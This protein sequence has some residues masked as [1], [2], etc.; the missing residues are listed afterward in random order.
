MQP[1]EDV[2]VADGCD[3]RRVKAA[4]V[5]KH[6]KDF[7]RDGGAR[8]QEAGLDGERAVD[9]VPEMLPQQRHG[10]VA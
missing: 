8:F 4:Q 10:G 6:L 2:R 9:V 5:D 3:R 1:R 7:V